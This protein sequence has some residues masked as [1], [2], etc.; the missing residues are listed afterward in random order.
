MQKICRLTLFS[1]MLLAACA[2]KLAGHI[3]DP[4]FEQ[5]SMDRGLSHPAV[6]SVLQD[7]DGFLWFGT[8]DGLNRFD[9]YNFSIFRNSPSDTTSLPHNWVTCLCRSKLDM[10]RHARRRIVSIQHRYRQIYALFAQPKRRPILC[11][12]HNQRPLV[13]WRQPV[14]DWNP[15]RAIPP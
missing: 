2:T 11:R 3:R 5:I 12:Q 10:G 6:S 14:M 15:E 1:A 4:K 8:E 7:N 13:R 9:G